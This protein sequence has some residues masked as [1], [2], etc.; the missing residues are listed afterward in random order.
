M[1]WGRFPQ[2]SVHSWMRPF[3]ASRPFLPQLTSPCD[4]ENFAEFQREVTNLQ[5][6]RQASFCGIVFYY[7]IVKRECVYIMYM[8]KLHDTKIQVIGLYELKNSSGIQSL[9]R[10]I[11]VWT[12]WT[13]ERMRKW[14]VASDSI[15]R[16]NIKKTS[17][18]RLPLHTPDDNST[19][20]GH[21]SHI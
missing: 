6:L 3:T 16:S 4:Q 11:E 5:A 14:F 13:L 20:K 2:N 1:I 18:G 17:M 19:K 10:M 15:N 8:T 9:P 12:S 7:Y 21:T